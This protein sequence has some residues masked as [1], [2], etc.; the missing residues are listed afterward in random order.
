MPT[1]KFKQFEPSG[2]KSDLRQVYVTATDHEW[3]KK[4]ASDNSSRMVW[5]VSELINHARESSETFKRLQS[6]IIELDSL[7]PDDAEYPQ[8]VASELDA[9]AEAM[10]TDD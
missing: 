4:T 5:V 3:I 7:I 2:G 1:L 8:W 6:L 9:M 10:K